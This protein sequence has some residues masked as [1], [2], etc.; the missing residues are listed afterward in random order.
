MSG[1]YIAAEHPQKGLL[2]AAVDPDARYLESRVGQTRLGAFVAP[3]PTEQ[4]ATDALKAT[5]AVIVDLPAKRK[6]A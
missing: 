5:G 2:Y 6:R 1:R 4:A 3:F